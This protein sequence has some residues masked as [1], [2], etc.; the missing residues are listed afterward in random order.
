MV[1][2]SVS[3][4]IEMIINAFDQPTNEMCHSDALTNTTL[5]G[6]SADIDMVFD[7]LDANSSPPKSVSSD[8]VWQKEGETENGSEKSSHSVASL[9]EL[10]ATWQ[11]PECNTMAGDYG[12]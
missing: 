2:H 7:Y 3:I 5:E 11:T 9:D 8:D 10:E 1:D 12:L 4:P 6:D